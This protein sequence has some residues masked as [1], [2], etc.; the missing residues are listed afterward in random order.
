MR[1]APFFLG[2]ILAGV[3]VMGSASA[4]ASHAEAAR[5][6]RIDGVTIASDVRPELR[7]NRIMV[8]LRVISENFGAEVAWSTSKVTIVKGQTKL[9]LKLNSSA[10]V[11]NGEAVQLDVKPYLKNNRV[12]VPI[13]F[14]AETFGC[15]VS[16]SNDTVSIESAP[17]AID[18]V[19]I[20]TLQHEYHM[21][22]GGVVQQIKASTY[23]EAFYRIFSENK[24]IRVDAPAKYSWHFQYLESG[25]YYKGGQFDF[26]NGNGD[27]VR[28]FDIYSLVKFGED[29]PDSPE[30]LLYDGIE[31]QWHLFSEAGRDMIN[32]ALS[33]AEANGFLTI[34][35][36]TVP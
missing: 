3:I 36:N 2:A 34:I 13:R 4:S 1:R 30:V 19:E 10:A 21:T 12:L 14:I 17:L 7:N 28:Q 27:I 18:Q 29:L 25:S 32:Q 8:P 23:H 31:N 15:Q 6:I 20:T 26:L 33:R 16:Y 24:G 5:Q 11:K 22:M 35:E 9:T